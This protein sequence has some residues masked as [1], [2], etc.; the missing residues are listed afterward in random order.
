METMKMPPQRKN[1]IPPALTLTVA[2]S[3]VFAISFALRL[4]AQRYVAPTIVVDPVKV[5]LAGE[6]ATPVATPLES[7]ETEPG[8]AAQISPAGG[9]LLFDSEIQSHLKSVADAKQV[10]SVEMTVS[11][12]YQSAGHLYV[13]VCF[14]G[15]GAEGWQMGPATLT[16]ANGGASRFAV[17]PTLDERGASDVDTG[18]HCETLEFDALPA[19]ADLS[20][21]NLRVES[22]LL[23][24]PEEFKE[25]EAY[26]ARWEK[27]DRM[28][29]LGIVAECSH[30]PGYIDFSLLSKP[31]G[32]TEEEALT[33]AGQEA[34]GMV[35]GP[36]IFEDLKLITEE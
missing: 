18:R 16:F 19:E 31:D 14:E 32:V 17:H 28:K 7:T 20:R 36:W 8:K 23:A 24:Y 34:M 35:V 15:Q 13:S 6:L 11:D 33:I 1:R 5:A 10:N 9:E 25:C 30:E 26:T 27:S 3:A 21:L 2:A 4:A 12:F 29:E 22:V